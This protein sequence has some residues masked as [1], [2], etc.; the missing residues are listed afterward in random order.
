V[1]IARIK[2]IPGANLIRVEK[3]KEERH[4]G[5][6]EISRNDNEYIHNGQG[7]PQVATTH[8]ASHVRIINQMSRQV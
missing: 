3:L 5:G 7:K 2:C 1:K 6:Y 4:S 8:E